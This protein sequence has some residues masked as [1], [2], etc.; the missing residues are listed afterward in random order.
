MNPSTE[1]DTR[2]R[3][4]HD[5]WNQAT[6]QDARLTMPVLR[7]WIDLLQL[8]Y[9]GPDIKRVLNYLRREITNGKR[10]PGALALRNFLLIENFEK[11]LALANQQ[12]AGTLD[13]NRRLPSLPEPLTT[14]SA[15][16]PASAPS[17]ER[18]TTLPGQIDLGSAL[19]AWRKKTG[20]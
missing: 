4:I 19:A 16:L 15:T 9:N 5:W 17:P 3:A 8:G 14:P 12:R 11:D 13:P 2:A 1:L 18:P 7:M 10:Q 20:I 6:G